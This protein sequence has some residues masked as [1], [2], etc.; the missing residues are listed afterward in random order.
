MPSVYAASNR[1]KIYFKFSRTFC[2]SKVNER[3]LQSIYKVGLNLEHLILIGCGIR[4]LPVNLFLFLPKL[5]VLD[6]RNNFLISLPKS[7]AYHPN[8]E[9]LFLGGNLFNSPPS[10]LQTLPRLVKHDIR[11]T[12]KNTKIQ[13]RKCPVV[14]TVSIIL[15]CTK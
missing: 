5:K 15:H 9:I 1:R 12:K 4:K 11:I 8:L 10:L 2:A 6:L 7:L 3:T 14:S 13:E